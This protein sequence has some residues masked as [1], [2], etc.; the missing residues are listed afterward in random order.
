V[1]LTFED[2]CT[3]IGDDLRERQSRLAHVREA[4]PTGDDEGGNRNRGRKLRRQRSVAQDLGFV[5]EGVRHGLQRRPE[6]GVVQL[7]DDINGYAN[8][9][10]LEQ[11]DRIAPVIRLYQ[12]P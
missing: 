3:R 5:Y 12:L 1:G 7:G 10:R 4:L 6:G 2:A 8:A 9:L 11:R